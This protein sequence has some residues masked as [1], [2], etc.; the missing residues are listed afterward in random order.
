MTDPD[1]CLQDPWTQLSRWNRLQISIEFDSFAWERA[2]NVL[3]FSNGQFSWRAPISVSTRWQVNPAN[4]GVYMDLQL[5]KGKGCI[6]H[7][8]GMSWIENPT[9]QTQRNLWWSSSTEA[10]IIRNFHVKLTQ[11]IHRQTDYTHATVSRFGDEQNREIKW[12]YKS[13]TSAG[14]T[15]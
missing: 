7:R 3:P 8:N 2:S 13:S 10:T 9:P 4:R 12:F 5:N 15:D 1:K 6:L 14:K 11:L